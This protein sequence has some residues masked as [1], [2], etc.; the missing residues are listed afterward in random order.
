MKKR[1]RKRSKL[2]EKMLKGEDTK[3]LRKRGGTEQLETAVHLQD[4]LLPLTTV[5][6]FK[7]YFLGITEV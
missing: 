3:E 6:N 1:L 4:L 2:I 7:K 5:S